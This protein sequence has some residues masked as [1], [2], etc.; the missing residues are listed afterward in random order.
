MI[1]VTRGLLIGLV[2]MLL[3][4]SVSFAHDW[5]YRYYNYYYS[6]PY[7]YYPYGY[8]RYPYVYYRSPRPYAYYPY[9]YRPYRFWRGYWR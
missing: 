3:L 2:M 4:P 1:A 6:H 9:G 7:V 5:G 8:Y